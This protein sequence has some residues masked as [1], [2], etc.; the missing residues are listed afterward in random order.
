[1]VKNAYETSH[2]SDILRPVGIL[3][4]IPNATGDVFKISHNWPFDF[5]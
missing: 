1:M 4:T 5:L 3:N 2:C